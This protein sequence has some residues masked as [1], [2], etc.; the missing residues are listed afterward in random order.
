MKGACVTRLGCDEAPLPIP[1]L[2][3][4]RVQQE[5]HNGVLTELMSRIMNQALAMENDRPFG[6]EICYRIC[7]KKYGG[8]GYDC[9]PTNVRRM[10][11]TIGLTERKWNVLVVENPVQALAFGKPLE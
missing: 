7:F 5:E 1:D 4:Y 10:L 2:P 11:E 8:C 9:L 3:E 6:R